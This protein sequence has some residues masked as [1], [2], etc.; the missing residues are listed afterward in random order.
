MN[1]YPFLKLRDFILKRS[2]V[3]FMSHLPLKITNVNKRDFK[4]YFIYKDNIEPKRSR[5][6]NENNSKLS[7]PKLISCMTFT[8]KN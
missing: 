3:T 1:I 7:V 8:L 6:R 2:N 4:P 5:Y